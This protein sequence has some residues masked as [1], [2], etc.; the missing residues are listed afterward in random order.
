M[1]RRNKK[2]L[3]SSPNGFTFLEVLVA[4]AILGIGF[5]LM[6]S[7]FRQNSEISKKGQDYYVASLIGQKKMEEIIQQGYANLHNSV[8]QTS[9]KP[10][11]YEENS[12]YGWMYKINAQENDILKVKVSITWPWPENTHHIDYSTLIANR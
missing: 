9:D 7:I 5:T 11:K 8:N 10:A 2:T 1:N 4:I 6:V 3:L 12:K